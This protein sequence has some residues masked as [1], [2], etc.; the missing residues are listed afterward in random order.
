MSA[1]FGWMVIVALASGVEAAEPPWLDDAALHDVAFVG[2]DLGWAVGDRGTIWHTED[3]GRTWRLQASGVDGPLRSVCFLT[4]QHGWAV[5][6]KT[7]PYTRLR[8]GIV[9]VTTDGGRTWL[10]LPSDQLPPLHS[11]RFFDLESGVAVGESSAVHR[12]GVFQTNDGGQTWQEVDGAR[13]EGWRAAAFPTPDAGVVAGLRG[14]LSLVGNGQMLASRLQELGLRGLH[15]IALQADDTGWLA[16]DGGLAMLTTSGGIVWQ[17]PPTPLPEDLRDVIDFHAVAVRGPKVW[18]AGQPG[19]VIWHSP[20]NGRTWRKQFTRQTVP[21]HALRFIT[22]TT[23]FAVGALGLVLRTDDGGETWTALRGGG[24][25]VALLGIHARSDQLSLSLTT[26]LA[27]EDGYRTAVLLPVRRDVGADAAT[28]RDLDVRLQEA[29]ATAGGSAVETSWQFP[30]TAPGLDQNT[31]R[32][33]ADWNRRTEGRLRETFLAN[34]VLQIRM[35]RPAVIVVDEPAP[36]DAAATLLRSAVLRAVENA[37]DPTCDIAQQ[38]LAGLSPWRVERVFARLPLGSTGQVHVDPNEYL[39]RLQSSIRLAVAEAA[40]QL[41]DASEASPR[42]EAYRLIWPTDQNRPPNDFFAGLE[43]EPGS[44]SRR[45]LLP[46]REA[47][48]AQHVKLAQQQRNLEAYLE[49]SLRDPRVAG[50]MLA[51]LDTLIRGLSEAQAARQLARLAEEYVQQSQIDLA[52]QTYLELLR[53]HPRQPAAQQG[54]TWLLHLWTS[55]EVGWQ[56]VRKRTVEQIDLTADPQVAA[57]RIQQTEF[58]LQMQAL[59][60]Q[61]DPESVI[62]RQI[63]LQAAAAAPPAATAQDPLR[64]TNRPQ[65]L[66]AGVLPGRQQDVR[67]LQTRQWLQQGALLAAEIQK[68]APA[69]FRTAEIQFPLG[70]LRRQLAAQGMTNVLPRS[71]QWATPN[72]NPDTNETDVTALA[73]ETNAAISFCRRVMQRPLLDGDL[74]DPCWQAARPMP[75]TAEDA[76]SDADH[77]AVV[78]LAYDRE[79]LYVAA[80]V[81]RVPRTPT[82]PPR[83]AGRA[84]DADLSPFD[85]ISLFLDLDRDYQTY[86]GFHVDQRGWTAERCWNDERWNPT[87]YVAAAADEQSWRIEAAIPLEELGPVPR[88]GTIWGVSVLRT[89]PA[90]GIQSWTHPASPRPGPESFGRLKFE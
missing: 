23:G 6:G 57:A 47:D 54:M 11:V 89:I 35:W 56:R 9:L 76:A 73:G 44:E 30:I 74:T 19:S 90:V 41:G 49:Q 53:R 37:A 79:F 8:T 66:Q 16:G 52:E 36:N 62:L 72:D 14:K 84:H 29:V 28:N 64:A 77:Q 70:A 46:Y 3:G 88:P 12:T 39:P 4:D 78:L 32:L 1:R 17:S 55:S 21:L 31:E 75:L 18:L 15:A 50:Q 65:A 42:R 59:E 26:K 86:Y 5:G 45:P 43:I 48:R 2:T 58:Q 51:Q 22:E 81:P 87:W 34:L 60:A 7:T 68:S 40:A 38:E 27:V 83:H 61:T 10:P 80:N 24:R 67:A 69:L 63:L 25:H 82:D 71:L 33:V 85:R 20:D 13:T